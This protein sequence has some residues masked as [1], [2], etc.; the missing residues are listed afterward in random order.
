[1]A[2]KDLRATPSTRTQSD[3]ML[4]AVACCHGLYLIQRWTDG[5]VLH[6]KQEGFM[7]PTYHQQQHYASLKHELRIVDPH[8]KVLRHQQVRREKERQRE[9]LVTI[10]GADMSLYSITSKFYKTQQWEAQV[11]LVLLACAGKEIKIRLYK[12]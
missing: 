8:K 9:N 11:L 4:E 10:V 6:R 2:S 5:R 1:M 7:A 12:M 3:S